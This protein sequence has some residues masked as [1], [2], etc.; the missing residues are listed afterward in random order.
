MTFDQAIDNAARV[1][2]LAEKEEK[3]DRAGSLL[4]VANTW[5]RV[6]ELINHH[7]AAAHK[8]PPTTEQ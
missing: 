3:V 4:T 6:A 8:E 1:L 7:N 5:V 2:D